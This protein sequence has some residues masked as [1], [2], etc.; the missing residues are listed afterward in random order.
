MRDHLFFL[1]LLNAKQKATVRAVC[2][3]VL[4]GEPDSSFPA[5]WLAFLGLL[6]DGAFAMLSG[7]PVVALRSVVYSPRCASRSYM[8]AQAHVYV[9]K[10]LDQIDA[11][12]K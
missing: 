6:Q 7:T 11:V 2:Y 10:V 12:K 1:L 9:V 8:C 3:V 4:S 5:G